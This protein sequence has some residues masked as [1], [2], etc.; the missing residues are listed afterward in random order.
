MTLNNMIATGESETVEFKRSFGNEAIET[1]CVLANN[2]AG[3]VFIGID[4]AGVKHGI[5]VGVESIQGYINQIK[6][7]TELSL[8]VD[9]KALKL[10]QKAILAIRV[11]EFPV[12]PV[13]FKGCTEI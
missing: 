8:M 2:V 4:D 11:E 9:I 5:S 3:Q 12:K 1:I 13:G 10:K 7:A 6:T